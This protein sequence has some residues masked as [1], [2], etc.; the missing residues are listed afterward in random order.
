MRALLLVLLSA[1]AIAVPPLAPASPASA[2]A[3]V[4]RLA[5]PPA[6]LRPGAVVYGDVPPLRAAPAPMH[7]HHP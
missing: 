5:G 4:G 1:C 3:P 7:H 6:T 2:S